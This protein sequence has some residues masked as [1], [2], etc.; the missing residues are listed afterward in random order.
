MIDER[1]QNALAHRAQPGVRFLAAIAGPPGAGKSTL[2]NALA[3]TFSGRG[4][5][6]KVVP[7]DGYH[8]DN[9]TL[10]ERGILD[11][12]GAPDTFDADR[13]VALVERLRNPD[14]T[15]PYPT[16]D[17][18]QDCVIEDADTVTPAHDL[19]LIEGNYLLLNMPPWD[20]LQS[21]FD[22]TLLIYPG[23]QILETRLTTRWL[24]HGHSEEAARL[25]AEGNDLPNARLVVKYSSGADLMIRGEE[26]H[27]R[28]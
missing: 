3:E 17:R 8:L 2:A 23:L 4:Y 14:A 20:Q 16:F 18:E 7:M 10:S 27:S 22:F 5:N 26:T 28:V 13:F 25:R 9:D 15:V 21:H 19:L 12:K 11:R 6:P 24:E 1:V